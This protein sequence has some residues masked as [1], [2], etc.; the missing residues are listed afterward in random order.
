VAFH[1]SPYFQGNENSGKIK[2]PT[3]NPGFFMVISITGQMD[4]SGR[5]R[6]VD[7]RELRGLELAARAKIYFQD[8]SWRVPSSS[9]SGYY[10]VDLSSPSCECEDFSLR[11]PQPCKHIIAA[12][13]VC[14]RDH[15]QVA[16][17]IDT[18]II[19]VKKSYKQDWPAYN[20]AQATEKHRFQT[21]LHDLCKGVVEPPTKPKGRKPHLAKDAIFAICFKVY[22]TFSGR[23]FTC[24][25]KD[26]HE[27][28]YL[29]APICGMK[30]N[31]LMEHA[32][33]TP[34]LKALIAHSAG[35]LRVIEKTFAIDSTGFS[36]SKF[37]RWYDQKYGTPRRRCV[38]IKAH[39]ASGTK[40]NVVTAV[41]ILDKDAGDAPQFKPLMQTTAERFQVEEASADAAYASV[42]NFETIANMGG[43][44]YA[45]FKS[46]TTGAV[47]GLF[48]RMFHYFQYRKEE[49]LQHY[50]RRSNVESTI[51]AVKRKFGDAVRSR[52]DTAMVNEVL[53]KFLC[54]NICCLIQEQCELK[55][56]PAFWPSE[57]APA[58]N[59][60]LRFPG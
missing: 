33:F 32:A 1:V 7:A 36:S 20:L 8:G 4:T 39:I 12:R 28:G 47:G 52:T 6:A 16:P 21:L 13:L 55:I 53:C 2:L 17:A 15:G 56:E 48:E 22:S 40:T 54:H 29:S 51:S 59:Q 49:F 31:H 24:D 11:R 27:R 9:G 26:A 58:G 25:L 3:F 42:E 45:A 35:P 43:T 60:I 30:V 19:P 10:R 41:R 37:E 44:L 14:E 38:W 18:E 57:E 50:H 5:G 23:R 34:I 46:S